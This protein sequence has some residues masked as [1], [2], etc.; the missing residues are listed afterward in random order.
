MAPATNGKRYSA[1][2]KPRTS[3][4]ASCATSRRLQTVSKNRADE[5]AQPA[6]SA[7]LARNLNPWSPEAK[8][9]IGVRRRPVTFSASGSFESRTPRHSKSSDAHGIPAATLVVRRPA[10][11]TVT[12]M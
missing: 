4:V 3:S 5:R 1:F 11:R 2:T 9:R 7:E 12:Q 8:R 10:R 6:M